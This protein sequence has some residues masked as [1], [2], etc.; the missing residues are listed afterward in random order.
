[1]SSFRVGREVQAQGYA[2]KNDD[3]RQSTDLPELT[4]QSGLD[5]HEY[6]TSRCITDA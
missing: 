5:G 3:R 6:R 1:M 2:V 4:S